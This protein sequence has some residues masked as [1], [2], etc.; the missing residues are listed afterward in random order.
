MEKIVLISCGSKKMNKRTKAKDMYQS[1]LFKNSLE[2]ALK[3]NP[4]KIFILSA[5]YGLLDL[6]TEI[7]PYDVTIS[8]VSKQNR[9]KKPQLKVLNKSEK[10]E[11]GKKII[12]K[13]A[14]FS[15]IEKDVFIILAGLEYVKPIIPYL[16]NV[17]QPLKG[18]GLF[19]RISHLKTLKNEI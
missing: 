7:E 2:Y 19:D 10:I 14:T 15:N 3:L 18:I 4:D 11:W 1:P 9:L 16:L 6:E 5:L 8:N 17:E 12:E 13:L